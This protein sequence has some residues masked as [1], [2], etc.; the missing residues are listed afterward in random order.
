MISSSISTSLLLGLLLLGL[1]RAAKEE[2]S[3]RQAV[4]CDPKDA[5]CMRCS[6]HCHLIPVSYLPECCEAYEA[7]CDQYFASCKQCRKH[8]KE[9]KFF[10]EYCCA[11][12]TS[13]CEDVST[14]DVSLSAPTTKVR[15]QTPRPQQ[16]VLAP[17]VPERPTTPLT[18]DVPSFLS[19]PAVPQFRPQTKPAPQTRPQTKR[20]QRPR[21][22]AENHERRRGRVSSRGR[23]FE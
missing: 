6:N 5:A 13:C 22:Q 10:P 8:V 21:A 19:S 23:V 18:S 7:C 15:S 1:A 4:G 17:P 16:P 2:R 20:P 11:S 3:R 14:L 12:F 9:D